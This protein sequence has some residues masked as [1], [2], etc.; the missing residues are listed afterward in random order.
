MKDADPQDLGIQSQTHESELV[1]SHDPTGDSC[2]PWSLQNTGRAGSGS[3][4][5]SPCP[6]L[7]LSLINCPTF[8]TGPNLS[9]LWS[10][11][12]NN[13]LEASFWPQLPHSL[14]YQ[15]PGLL[16]TPC[17]ENGNLVHQSDSDSPTLKLRLHFPSP[18]VC[19]KGFNVTYWGELQTLCWADAI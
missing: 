8:G 17:G 15:S 11:H 16:S 3:G 4:M 13:G 7:P 6:R 9:R 18:E 2:A 5:P 1:P 14:F 12:L 10:L 19:G